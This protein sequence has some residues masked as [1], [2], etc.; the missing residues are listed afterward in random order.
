MMADVIP[1]FN[2]LLGL[3]ISTYS[4]GEGR[5]L[6]S[7]GCIHFS[8]RLRAAIVYLRCSLRWY[9]IMIR[10]VKLMETVRGVSVYTVYIHWLSFPCSSADS[11][12]GWGRRRCCWP[13]LLCNYA[14]ICWSTRLL[15]KLAHNLHADSH[16][17]LGLSTCQLSL[18]LLVKKKRSWL[19]LGAQGWRLPL[20]FFGQPPPYIPTGLNLP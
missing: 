18:S 11:G 3:R 6:T 9:V 7:T 14:M 13:D 5:N 12:R 17:A 20:F 15:E 16:V 4:A 1:F 19:F 8:Q 10:K 2:S